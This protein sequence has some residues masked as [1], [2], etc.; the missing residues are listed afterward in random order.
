MTNINTILDFDLDNTALSDLFGDEEFTL[1][2]ID[3]ANFSLP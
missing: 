1:P 3:L 2:S